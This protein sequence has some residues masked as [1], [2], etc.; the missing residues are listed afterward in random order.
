MHQRIDGWGWLD[1]KIGTVGDGTS[2]RV[3]NFDFEGEFPIFVDDF[4][5]AMG[6]LKFVLKLFLVEYL[7]DEVL[8]C[9]EGDGVGSGKDVLI[10]KMFLF[11]FFVY[12]NIMVN[13]KV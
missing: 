8:V 3:D 9:E 6:G 12:W 13:I 2:I 1:E 11:L 4:G 5:D 10:L 7:S